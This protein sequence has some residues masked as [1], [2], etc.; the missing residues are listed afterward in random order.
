[1]L[2]LLG[3]LSFSKRYIHVYLNTALCSLCKLQWKDNERYSDTLNTHTHTHTYKTPIQS[4]ILRRR[5]V[6]E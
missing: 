3:C 2:H 1:M 5:M 4:L 6:A